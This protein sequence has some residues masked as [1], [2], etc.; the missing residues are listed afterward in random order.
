MV[1]SLPAKLALL[2]KASSWSFWIISKFKLSMFLAKAQTHS[3]TS[4]TCGFFQA[5]VM[6]SVCAFGDIATKGEGPEH[7][8]VSWTV[9]EKLLDL[10]KSNLFECMPLSPEKKENT[11]NIRVHL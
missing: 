10:Q 8:S 9:K 1:H 7:I 6:N 5:M 2:K 11:S 3:G 4:A